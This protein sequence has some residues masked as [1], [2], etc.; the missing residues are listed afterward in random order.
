VPARA[1]ASSVGYTPS[2]PSREQQVGPELGITVTAGPG[3][4]RRATVCAV[5]A[6]G[7]MAL[8]LH[9]TAER[10]TGLLGTLPV[11]LTVA[12]TAAT[13]TSAF[14]LARA[15]ALDSDRLRW[16][17]AGYALASLAMALQLLGFPGLAEGGGPLGTTSSG[18]AGLYLLWHLALGTFALGATGPA[19]HHRGLR[20]LAVGIGLALI[21]SSGI[22]GAPFPP[23]LLDESG[24]YLPLLR[25]SIAVALLVGLAGVVAWHRATRRDRL[26]TEAWIGVSLTLG[27]LDLGLHALGGARFTPWWWASLAMRIAEFTVPAVAIA[28]GFVRLFNLLDR[29][30][31]ALEEAHAELLDV[32]GELDAFAGIVA[33]DLRGP[34]MIARG[35][36]ETA[37]H[38]SSEPEVRRLL[39]RSL[40]GHDRGDELIEDLLS[41]ARARDGALECSTVDLVD[42]VHGALHHLP[43]VPSPTEVVEL[44]DVPTVWGDVGALRQL[45]HNLVGNA[46]RYGAAGPRSVRVSGAPL[47]DGGW[48]VSVEDRGPGIAPEDRARV[49]EPFVRLDGTRHLGGTGLGLAIARLVVERHGGTVGVE[50]RA[51]GGSTFWFTLPPAPAP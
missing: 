26:W 34:L 31:R 38:C 14:L 27:L 16:I 19:A 40:Q 50:P 46:V 28:W 8:L 11:A 51:G 9:V 6:A 17:G 25:A 45:V 39:E 33:H 41:L 4:V 1:E 10:G 20:R 43:D 29:H 42:L 24:H 37:L 18:A 35:F 12:A 21:L 49:F 7:G 3:L 5:L 47:P 2:R 15:T 44:V 30:A 13:G 22:G 23:R 48:R 36:A 32:N